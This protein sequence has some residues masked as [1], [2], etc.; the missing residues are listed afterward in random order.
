MKASSTSKKTPPEA[1][2]SNAPASDLKGSAPD[3]RDMFRDTSRTEY[4]YRHICQALR[5]GRFRQGD[6]IREDEVAKMLGVSRTPVR[7]A[8][9]RLRSRGLIEFTAG[10]GAGVIVLSRAQVL[11]L[12]AM[13]EILEGAAARM[14]AEHATP[15]EISYLSYVMDQFGQTKD[16]ARMAQVN[17]AFHRSISDGAHN[18]YLI[19]S[20]DQLRDALAL[21]QGTTFSVKGRPATADAEHRAIYEA[22]KNRDADAAEQ[23]ARTHIRNARMARM[24]MLPI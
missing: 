7:E 4:V 21:L 17:V 22:I 9:L 1:V 23:A 6:R 16:P 24:Q 11:E 12:Y 3:D 2:S 20:L 13:R 5:E 19:E 10:R 14:A 15:A 8:L 18:Q